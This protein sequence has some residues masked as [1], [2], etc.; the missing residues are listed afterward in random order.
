[1]A[2]RACGVEVPSTLV[3]ALGCQLGKTFI[4]TLQPPRRHLQPNAHGP[5]GQYSRYN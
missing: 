1:M 2:T 3:Y 4:S 5:F